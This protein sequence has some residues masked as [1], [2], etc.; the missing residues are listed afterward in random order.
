M[1]PAG[2]DLSVHGTKVNFSN[3]IT[4]DLAIRSDWF[5]QDNSRRA[6]WEGCPSRG[7]TPTYTCSKVQDAGSVMLHEFGH[8]IGLAHPRQ[9]DIHIYGVA[10]NQVMSIAKC[11]V[12]LDQATMCQASDAPGGGQYRTHR[13][14]LDTWD[15]SSIAASF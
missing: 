6:L 15:T 14:T 1:S 9:T 8:A 5:T 13:R 3:V 2:C 4:V 10:P 12:V 7:Y 11:G